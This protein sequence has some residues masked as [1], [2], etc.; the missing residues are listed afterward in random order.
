MLKQHKTFIIL[1]YVTMTLREHS[2]S[3]RN[4]LSYS[5]VFIYALMMI[6]CQEPFNNVSDKVLR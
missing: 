5:I 2:I 1:I 4:R 6:S 3:E